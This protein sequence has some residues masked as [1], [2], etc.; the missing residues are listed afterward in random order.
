VRDYVAAKVGSKYLIQLLWSGETPEEIPFDQLPSKFVIKATHG[1]AYNIIVRNKAQ[2]DKEAIRLQLAVWLKTN[3]AQEFLLGVEW[4]YKNIEPS[5][6]IE[7]FMEENEQAPVDYK[8]Y[9]FSGRV[10]ILTLHFDRIKDHKTKAFNRN[11]E[12]HNFGPE[13]KQYNGE[14]QRPSNFEEMV[15]LAES[16]S[17]E[18][19][20]IRVDLYNLKN[21][22]YFGE[23][24][25]YP[26]GVS[27]LRGFDIK[28]Q[29]FV[30]GKKW[31]MKNYSVQDD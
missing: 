25:P 20:F 23:L 11:F 1:S 29:D 27:S 17:E 28:S 18:F 6:I 2:I 4:G 5:I 26:G 3:Y 15:K 7:S 22:I 13:F 31:K 8:F 21:K 12:P 14:Y 10:E 24:T 30:L 19:D 16:L 9:C